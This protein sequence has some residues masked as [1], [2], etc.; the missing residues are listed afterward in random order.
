MIVAAARN[1][2][3]GRDNTL[4]WRLQD[5]L[6][7]FRRVTMG[8]PVIMGRHTFDS[9]GRPL[10]GRDNIVV[11]RNPSFMAAG[12]RVVH[13]LDEAFAVALASAQSSGADEVMLL[14][15]AQ[16]YAAALPRIQR[17]Y[18]TQVHAD[19]AGDVRLPSLEPGSWQEISREDHPAG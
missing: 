1:G 11:S 12:T 13:D 4:P 17:V 5:D 15:G 14:G 18:L 6:R 19:I 10:P 3:I 7:Y 16:L 2:T 9:I 8:K